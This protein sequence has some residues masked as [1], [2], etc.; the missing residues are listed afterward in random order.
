MGLADRAKDL[1]SQ[2]TDKVKELDEQG[3]LDGV[4]A[5][6][7]ELAEKGVDAGERK[8]GRQAPDAVDHHV[9]QIDGRPG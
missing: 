2:A 1:A 4:K 7:E 3:K 9:D 6:A 5:K 8:T